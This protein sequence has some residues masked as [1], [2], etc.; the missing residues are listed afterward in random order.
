MKR[1]V[2]CADGTWNVRDQLDE[3]TGKRRPTNVTKLARAVLPRARDGIDQI[4]YYDEGVGTSGGMDKVT[5]GAFGRGIEHNVRDIYRFLIYNYEEGDEIYLF[6]FS[7]GA[8]T[9]RTLTGFMNLVG[10]LDKGDDY[11]VPDVFSCYENNVK[12]DSEQWRRS[13]HN[14]KTQRECPPIRMIGVWDTVGSLGAPGFLGRVVNRG[15]YKYHDVTLNAHVQNA[16]HA[17]AID[18]RRSPFA[19]DLWLRPDGWQGQLEQVWFAGVHSNIGGGY[20]PDGLANEALHWM[21]E[22]AEGLGLQFNSAYLNFFPPVYYSDLKDSMTMVYRAMGINVREI[23]AHLEHGEAIHQSALDRLGEASCNYRPDNLK[24]H[25]D[26]GKA[27]VVTTTRI[28]RGQ[29]P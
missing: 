29:K 25:V 1:I 16:F 14:V 4:V 2:I 9:A 7:R 20:T 21:I 18:E 19:P 17:I 3:T 12:P 22:K 8:F 23:G 24:R 11:Y 28:A 27:R 5:G 6:G 26:S 10:L 13:F 15:K